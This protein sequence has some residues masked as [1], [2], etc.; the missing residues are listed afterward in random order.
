M[1]R[2]HEIGDG[3]LKDDLEDIPV[4]RNSLVE[5]EV[6]CGCG[7]HAARHEGVR[8][9]RMAPEKDVAAEIIF[10]VDPDRLQI[11]TGK[12]EPTRRLFGDEPDPLAPEVVDGIDVV[13][14]SQRNDHSLVAVDPF[15][16]RRIPA[17]FG[18]EELHSGIEPLGQ[19]V[20]YGR[21][22]SEVHAPVREV[23]HHVLITAGRHDRNFRAGRSPEVVEQGLV[24]ATGVVSGLAALPGWHTKS[25]QR[26][27]EGDF[28]GE[29]TGD[30]DEHNG[31]PAACRAHGVLLAQGIRERVHR[32]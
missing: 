26:L 19:D 6:P 16:V 5:I 7:I 17:Q 31:Y 21:D 9:P 25:I 11:R 3:G 28:A 20:R 23:V 24:T 30:A 18:Q 8:D 4:L 2:D 22:G 14:R 12:D 32:L 27:G 29:R 13:P 1:S 10:V 15:G